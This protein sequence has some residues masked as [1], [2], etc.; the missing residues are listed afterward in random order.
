MTSKLRSRRYSKWIATAKHGHNSKKPVFDL[1]NYDEVYTSSSRKEQ[2]STTQDED[3]FDNNSEDDKISTFE[4]LKNEILVRNRSKPHYFEDENDKTSNTFIRKRLGVHGRKNKLNNEE[5]VALLWGALQVVSM[6]A[7]LDHSGRVAL[8]ITSSIGNSLRRPIGMMLN[9]RKKFSQLK[10]QLQQIDSQQESKDNQVGQDK[11]A[12]IT[13]SNDNRDVS[14]EGEIT[15]KSAYL[16]SR[17]R[18]RRAAKE[19]EQ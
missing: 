14:G 2:N 11:A 1:G 15:D 4:K 5:F 19:Q 18:R 7:M 16:A 6:H 10:E 9:V 8:C 13:A 3:D 12:A 17:A